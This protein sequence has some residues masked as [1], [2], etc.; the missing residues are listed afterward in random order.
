MG[1]C[2]KD[3]LA[4]RVVQTLNERNT[5]PCDERIDG[6]I[7]TVVQDGYARYML[8]GKDPCINNWVSLDS[9]LVKRIG[10]ATVESLEDTTNTYLD[11]T[12]PEALEG[13]SLTV[14]RDN[15]SYRKT[16]NGWALTSSIENG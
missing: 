1:R 12:F 7:V 2:G 4:Y 5:I 11:R 10:G 14:L 13:F 9:L 6:M 3:V 16:S 8:Q 15:S